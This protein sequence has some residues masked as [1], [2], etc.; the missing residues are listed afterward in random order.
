MLTNKKTALLLLLL[1]ALSVAANA[2]A[3]TPDGLASYYRLVFCPIQSARGFIAGWLPFSLGDILYILGGLWLV[4]AMV[5]TMQQLFKNGLTAKTALHMVLLAGNVLLSVYLFFLIGWGLNYARQ[6]LAAAWGLPPAPKRS[7]YRAQ[8]TSY[9]QYLINKLND[10]APGYR[11]L[12]YAAISNR[13]KTYYRHHTDSRVSRYGIHVKPSLFGGILERLAIEGYY[14]P[15]TG[16]GQANAGQPSFTL[17][18]LICHEAAHQAGIAAEGD[19]N[20]MAYAVSISA[21]D[22]TF[23][24]AAYLNLWLYTHHRMYRF[25]S[26]NA[27]HM[28]GMLNPLTKAHIDTLDQI[29]RRY[30]N[31]MAEYSSELYDSYLKMQDQKDGIRSYGNVISSAWVW[32]LQHQAGSTVHIPEN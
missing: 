8:V 32:E 14:N 15:F 1:L 2:V 23:R 18:Y 12:T 24:Y 26:A 6:P 25:D 7:E 3:G 5:S 21:P 19:A 16:E 28:L 20:L 4:F 27:N 31:N 22:S 10:Y 29:S 17:P 30:Q 9:H 13:A 11:T